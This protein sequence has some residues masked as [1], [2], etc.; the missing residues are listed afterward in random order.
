MNNKLINAIIFVA[1]AAIGSAI[2]WK[3]V[4]TKYEQIAKD[5][6]TIYR[7]YCAWT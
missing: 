1:G 5:F 3:I 2:T 7:R 4:K 6:I